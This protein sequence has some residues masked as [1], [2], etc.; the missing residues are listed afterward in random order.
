MNN[1]FYEAHTLK[2][3]IH[4]SLVAMLV[5]AYPTFALLVKGANSFIFQVIGY[6]KAEHR[7]RRSHLKNQLGDALNVVLAVAGYNLL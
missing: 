4:Y 5:L 3:R 7:M 6:L 2:N 1:P